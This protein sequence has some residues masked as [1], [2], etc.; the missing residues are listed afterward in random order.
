MAPPLIWLRCKTCKLTV[1]L[2]PSKSAIFLPRH[3]NARVTGQCE[4]QT[5]DML[6][7]MRDEDARRADV[8]VAR[9][10]KLWQ[11]K[12]VKG[13]VARKG[14][15]TSRFDGTRSMSF[16]PSRGS[17]GAPTLGKRR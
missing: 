14:K 1:R 17:A 15:G 4:D 8:E 12:T 5:F 16:R 11:M 7:E 3:L 9:R 2:G 13:K 10:E 6:T